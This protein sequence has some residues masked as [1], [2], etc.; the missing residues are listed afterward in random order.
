VRETHPK[1][2]LIAKPQID[3]L[4]VK[5]YLNE[6]GG[7]AWYD[8]QTAYQPQNDGEQVVEFGG[9]LCYR[10][11]DVGLNPNVSKVRTDSADYFENILKSGHGSVIE[12]ANYTFLFQDVSRVFTHE[13]VRHRAGAAYSQESMRFVRL[14]EIPFWI[15]DWARQDEWL[16]D[17]IYEILE[18]LEEFQWE[19]AD[20]FGLDKMKKC[21]QCDGRGTIKNPSRIAGEGF[22]VPCSKCEG[23]GEVSAVPFHEKKAKTSFMRRFAPDGVSTAVMATFNLRALRHVI[24]MRTD[25]GA[26]EEIRLVFDQVAQI[27]RT[28]APLLFQDFEKD[29]DGWWKP[30]YV[31]V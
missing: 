18:A 14:D 8:R 23:K 10:S 29:A 1:V 26:E 5:E 3:W 20:H 25:P 7:L 27:M 30:K 28:E 6:I 2:I 31:K 11:F 21:D 22:A 15:P 4:A 13:L 9:R 19:M 12:H 17:R 16:M 24:K